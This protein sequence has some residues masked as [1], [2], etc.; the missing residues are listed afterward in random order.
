[1][2]TKVIVGVLAGLAVGG[3]AGGYVGLSLAEKKR[4][5][6]ADAVLRA[7]HQAFQPGSYDKAI[8]LAFAVT[9]RRPG[10]YSAY[11]IVADSYAEGNDVAR[12]RTFYKRSLESLSA[13]DGG[14]SSAAT[15]KTPEQDEFE[16]KRIS[17]KLKAHEST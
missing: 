1:M 2:N 16:K 13:K 14:A 8:E 12:A 17:A 3:L 4:A 15:A 9:D 6:S 11:E 10:L 7:A 5:D